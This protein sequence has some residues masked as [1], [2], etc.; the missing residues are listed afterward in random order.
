MF[1]SD[2]RIAALV[3]L[4]YGMF[5]IFTKLSPISARHH[6]PFPFHPPLSLSTPPNYV[7]AFF[8]PYQ[9]EARLK[10]K[11]LERK[12][13]FAFNF[14]VEDEVENGGG[15]PTGEHIDSERKAFRFGF[16]TPT[17]ESTD[18]IAA[19]LRTTRAPADD[20]RAKA[21]MT[22]HSKSPKPEHDRDKDREEWISEPITNGTKPKKKKGRSKKKGK[23]SGKGNKK[24]QNERCAGWLA[25]V[26]SAVEGENIV[27]DSCIADNSSEFSSTVVPDPTLHGE[28]SAAELTR[29]NSPREHNPVSSQGICLTSEAVDRDN[30]CPEAVSIHDQAPSSRE[31]VSPTSVA[32]SGPRLPPGLTLESWRDPALTDDERRRRR[33]GRGVRN[34]AAIQRRQDARRLSVAPGGGNSGKTTVGRPHQDRDGVV[35]PPIVVDGH[36]ERKDLGVGSAS[37]ARGPVSGGSSVF[38]F[39]FDIGISFNG[40]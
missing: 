21:A 38:A 15:G 6:F 30:I 40:S 37:E 33:F 12:K 18:V 1:T 35:G 14:Q 9:V 20:G 31:A 19:A 22:L 29:H 4:Q 23:G 28:T 32:A 25:A 11:L 10:Q 5:P 16:G 7:P 36:G 3:R 8:P 39:G 2:W 27:R 17:E 13:G 24:K 34:M 26:D